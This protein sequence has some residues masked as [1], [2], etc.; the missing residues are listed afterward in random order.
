ML[1]SFPSG[2]PSAGPSSGS[3]FVS[4]GTASGSSGT[5]S[6]TYPARTS[7]TSGYPNP[8]HSAGSDSTV[9]DS[10][11]RITSYQTQTFTSYVTAGPSSNGAGNNTNTDTQAVATSFPSSVS[12]YPS[13]SGYVLQSPCTLEHP[14]TSLLV[15]HTHLAA[16]TVR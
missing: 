8:S 14:L 5:G 11:I 12:G 7:A 4:S 6:G 3:Y 2:G 16:S 13:G 1:T 15:T 9:T 10:T